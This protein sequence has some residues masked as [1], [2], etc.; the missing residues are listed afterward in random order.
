VSA[1]FILAPGEQHP[2]APPLERPFFRFASG[3]TDGLAALAEVGLPPLTAGPNLHVHAQEDEMF[4]VLDGVM[5]VQVGD[6]LQEIAAG[7]L[8]WGARGTPHAFANRAKDPLRIMIMWIPGGAE[9]LFQDVREYLLA[10]GGA[11]DPQVVT[12]LQAR[13]GCTHVGP[14]I[15]IPGR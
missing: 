6:Q 5:T 10:A 3:Q 9:G 14:P 2:G 15:P 7:G 11:P 13:Y 1:P 4:F 8:A 12:G